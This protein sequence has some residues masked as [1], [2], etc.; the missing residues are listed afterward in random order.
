MSPLPGRPALSPQVLRWRTQWTSQHC[1]GSAARLLAEDRC[2]QNRLEL[3]FQRRQSAELGPIFT[4]RW[5]PFHESLTNPAQPV[6]LCIS[7]PSSF[8]GSEPDE[9]SDSHSG[10]REGEETVNH[11]DHTPEGER[12]TLSPP[13]GKDCPSHCYGSPVT[14][15]LPSLCCA[16][17]AVGKNTPCSW[18][19]VK[20]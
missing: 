17:A 5:R 18:S 4:P 6:F 13:L 20:C 11:W 1:H 15:K 7:M 12:P 8:F 2:S 9:A 16:W 10:A 14:T 3:P 19:T